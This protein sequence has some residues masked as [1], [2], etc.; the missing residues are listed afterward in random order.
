[1]RKLVEPERSF[2]FLIFLSHPRRAELQRGMQ[3]HACSGDDTLVRLLA[4]LPEASQK[5]Q[6]RSVAQDG[7]LNSGQVKCHCKF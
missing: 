1:M 2:N 5:S 3:T 4:G 6:A 7:V